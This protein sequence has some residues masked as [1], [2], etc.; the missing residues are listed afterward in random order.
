MCQRGFEVGKPALRGDLGRA[1][2]LL[3]PL[4][5]R[6][7]R[8]VLQQLRGGPFDPGM[9]RLGETVAKLIDESRLADSGLANDLNE[10][11][12]AASRAASA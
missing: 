11:P 1:K 9:G 6:M 3:A 7:Q 12:V 2:S 5:Q 10:L 4:G 8:R